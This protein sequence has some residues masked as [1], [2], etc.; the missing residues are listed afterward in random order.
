MT[1]LLSLLGVLLAVAC[2]SSPSPD[3]PG[4]RL[5]SL[6]PALTETVAALGA[7]DQLVARSDFCTVPPQVQRL[8][9]AGTALTPNLESLARLRPSRILIDGSTGS[10]QG[11]LA[12]L[13]TVEQLPWLTAEQ[14]AASTRRLGALVGRTERAERLATELEAAMQTDPPSSGPQ[15]LAVLGGLNLQDGE[16]WYIRRDS[17][18]GAALHAAGARNALN[19]DAS[20]PPS[21]SLEALIELDPPAIIVL[22]GSPDGERR[23]EILRDW[24]RLSTLRAVRDDKVLVVTGANILSTGPT[25]LKTVDALRDAVARLGAPEA[26]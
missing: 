17:L 6:S 24:Q 11:D 4:P 21:L 5:A 15:V 23:D 22:D 8:P 3:P 19:A 26:P 25:I 13:A 18:H 16:V 1:R 12:K 9:A 2:T 20:G 14:V 7:L 10:K